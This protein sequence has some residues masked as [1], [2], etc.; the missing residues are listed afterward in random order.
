MQLISI[1]GQLAYAATVVAVIIVVGFHQLLH[2]A[3]VVVLR[4]ISVFHKIGAIMLRHCLNKVL[5]NF[6]RN[7]GVP[8]VDFCNI[9]LQD[10]L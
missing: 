10:T 2:E 9:G 6:V 7:K 4:K 1:G 3:D 8:K 5:D